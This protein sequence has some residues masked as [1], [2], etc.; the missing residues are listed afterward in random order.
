MSAKF[1]IKERSSFLR[2]RDRLILVALLAY[3]API[4]AQPANAQG[5][6][7][8]G[9][10]VVETV[11]IACHGT[12]AQGAPKLGD[13]KAWSKRASQGLTGLTQ[14][15][16]MGIR[17][18]P[19]HGGN[20]QITDLEIGRAVTYMVNKSG[21]RWVEPVSAKDMAAER[22]GEQVVKA[23][24]A[25]CHQK[26]VG[27]APKIGD[28]NAWVPRMKQ[29]IDYLVRSAIRGHGGMPSRGGLADLTDAEIKNA[30]TYMFNP[31]AAPAG[32]TRGA[33]S[34]AN[35]AAARPAKADPNHMIVNGMEIYLGFVPAESLLAYPAESIERTMHGGVPRE[36]GYYHVN[37]SLSDHAS[38]APIAGAQVDVQVE[39]AGMTSESKTLEP[40]AIGAASYGNYFR[41]M[42]KTPYL[43][44]VRVRTPGSSRT[45]EARFQHRFD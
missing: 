40:M 16:L 29:G 28:K 30:V 44:T 35:V 7:R 23:Q 17:Q 11:C 32:D 31:V 18:M 14:H 38:N 34:A 6:G 2:K 39:Q 42:E 45:I 13:K 33:R 27:G 26:G 9:K 20:P 4:T 37:V 22:S 41:M 24:C 36:A 5:S 1:R 12:G 43:I 21:G 10:E 8:S 15:A 3:A 25:K 19:A